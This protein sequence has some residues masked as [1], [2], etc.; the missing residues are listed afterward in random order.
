MLNSFSSLR[1]SR[2]DFGHFAKPVRWFAL[3]ELTQTVA[4]KPQTDARIKTLLGSSGNGD[5]R[6]SSVGM[7]VG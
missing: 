4:I 6:R 2:F 7:C 3:L 1:H 5:W